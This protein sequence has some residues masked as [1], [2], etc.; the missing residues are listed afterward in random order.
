M[1]CT[2]NYFVNKVFLGVAGTI[3]RLHLV[4]IVSHYIANYYPF[5]LYVFC[6]QLFLCFGSKVCVFVAV[7][8]NKPEKNAP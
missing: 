4:W 8:V 5:R 1:N 7:V 3:K 2:I 6:N